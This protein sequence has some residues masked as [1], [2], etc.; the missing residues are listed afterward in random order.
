MVPKRAIRTDKARLTKCRRRLVRACYGRDVASAA[1]ITA[2]SG[3][4]CW[5]GG[6]CLSWMRGHGKAAAASVMTSRFRLCNHGRAREESDPV[7]FSFHDLDSF[8]LL[9]CI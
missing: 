6:G 2:R 7:E 8:V 4:E 1:E 9:F 3:V 5:S